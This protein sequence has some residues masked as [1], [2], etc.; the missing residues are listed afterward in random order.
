MLARIP[1]IAKPPKRENDLTTL[2]GNCGNLAHDPGDTRVE[3]KHLYSSLRQNVHGQGNT[4]MYMAR[5]TC[6]QKYKNYPG[7]VAYTIHIFCLDIHYIFLQGHLWVYCCT[8]EEIRSNSE[9]SKAFVGQLT[10]KFM[11]VMLESKQ[12]PDTCDFF[13]S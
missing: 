12:K 13:R 5:V 10:F 8:I 2:L 11:I 1:L 7:I 9:C 3:T 4:K 6:G